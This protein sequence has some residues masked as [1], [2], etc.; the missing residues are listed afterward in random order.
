MNLHELLACVALISS[1]LV[2]VVL[3]FYGIYQE[4]GVG[5]APVQTFLSFF[6][7]GPFL[8]AFVFCGA[9]HSKRVPNLVL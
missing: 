7:L 2:C 4:F 1:V 6:S 5:L 9:F 8:V 3:H